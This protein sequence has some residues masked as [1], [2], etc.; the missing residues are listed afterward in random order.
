M[1]SAAGSQVGVSEGNGAQ[2]SVVAQPRS[3]DEA[4]SAAVEEDGEIE[5]SRALFHALFPGLTFP[6]SRWTIQACNQ[7][8]NTDQIKACKQP[9]IH[10]QAS[11]PISEARGGG[12]LPKVHCSSPDDQQRGLSHGPGG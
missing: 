3:L 5:N 8:P 10:R 1:S 12:L 9:D 7:P 11:R 2:G 4:L 6:S